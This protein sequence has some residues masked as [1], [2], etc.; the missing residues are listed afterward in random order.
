M[1]IGYPFS[2]EDMIAAMR[3][4]NCNCGPSALAFALQRHISEV[5]GTIPGFEDK[6]YTSPTMMQAGLRNFGR[7]YWI[8]PKL[9]TMSMFAPLIALTRIQWHGPWTDPGANPKWAYRQTHWI[10]TWQEMEERGHEGRMTIFNRVFDCNSGI[11]SFEEWERVTVPTLIAMYPR[12]N[13]KWS[14][15]HIW[16]LKP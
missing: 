7:S 11:T 14:P 4:W 15:T 16:R 2:S 12:A 6:G 5:R 3:E 13:G 1:R 10:A 9:S 8:T